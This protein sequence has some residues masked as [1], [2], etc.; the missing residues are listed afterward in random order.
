M[1]ETP[2]RLPFDLGLLKLAELNS[3]VR[4]IEV[5]GGRLPD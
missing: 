4:T 1:L 3:A 5:R 2:A